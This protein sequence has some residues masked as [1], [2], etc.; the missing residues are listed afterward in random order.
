MKGA[1]RRKPE[2]KGIEML[3]ILNKLENQKTVPNALK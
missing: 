1:I 3:Q 2:E